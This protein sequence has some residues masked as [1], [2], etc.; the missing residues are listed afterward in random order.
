MSAVLKTNVTPPYRVQIFHDKKWLT[1][2]FYKTV[3]AAEK[4]KKFESKGFRLARIQKLNV[5]C[6]SRIYQTI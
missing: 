4:S 2:G 1:I 3:E 5:G 6:I